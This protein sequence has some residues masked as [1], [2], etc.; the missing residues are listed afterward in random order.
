MP[1]RSC[2]PWTTRLASRSHTAIIRLLRSPV[3]YFQTPGISCTRE[4]RPTPI[5]PMLMRFEGASCP[6]TLDGTMAGKPATA[7][8]PR[9]C[10]RNFLRDCPVLAIAFP[11]RRLRSRSFLCAQTHDLGVHLG[12]NNQLRREKTLHLVLRDVRSV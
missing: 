11:L 4:M 2:F 6:K 7:T 9:P 8:A 12:L 1:F 10:L 5:A 3:L